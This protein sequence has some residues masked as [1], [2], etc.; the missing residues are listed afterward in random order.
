MRRSLALVVCVEVP[1]AVVGLLPS[2]N[3]PVHVKYR[4]LLAGSERR[5]P[6]LKAETMY[7]SGP[8]SNSRDTTVEPSVRVALA[9]ESSISL[10]VIP[11]FGRRAVG[12]PAP[13]GKRDADHPRSGRCP[14][15]KGG[16]P[17]PGRSHYRRTND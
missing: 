9:W 5:R 1:A 13:G 12:M 10:Q 11:L 8:N 7:P 16:P 2:P 17:F 4:P 15:R 14:E 6:G 3:H